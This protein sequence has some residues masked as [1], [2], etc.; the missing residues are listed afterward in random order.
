M[1]AVLNSRVFILAPLGR[2]AAIA[3][4]LLQEA[5]IGSEICADFSAFEGALGDDTC[6]CVVTEEALRSVDLSIVAAHVREQP[7]WSDLPF[8]ILTHRGGEADRNSE[9]L[10]ELLGNVTFLERPFRPTTFV[11]VARTAL[12]GRQRQYEARTRIEQL[13]EGEER[14]RTALLA[15]HLGSWELDVASRTLTASAT[16]KA[17]F[18]R[19]A[20]EPFSYDDLIASIHPDDSERMQEAVRISIDRGID[21]AIEYR[22]VWRDRTVHWAEIRARLV[23]DRTTG[24]SRL[25]GVSADITE[26][27]AAEYGLK[28]LNETL[29]ERVAERTAELNRAHT[30][31]LAQIAQRQHTEELLRQS[32]KMD[33]IGQLT[34]GIAHDFNNLLMAVLGNLTLLRKQPSND[35]RTLRLIEGAL[36]GAERGAALTQRLL[37]FARRQEL[38]LEP[39]SLVDL[40]RGMNDLIERSAGSQVE[41]AFDL[42]ETLP[43]A[44]VDANQFELALLNL[45]VNAR[46]AMP[47]GGLLTIKVDSTQVGA[48]GELST[49][50]YVRLTVSD[51]GQGMDAETLRKATEPFFSTKGVGKGTG[52]G[53]S[54]IQGLA[55]QMN[56]TLRLKS[57]LG[58]GATAE[59][60]IPVTTVHAVKQ[61]TAAPE[62]RE[63]DD[64]KI[65][66][67]VV[68]DDAL[69]AMSTVD[70]LEDLGHEVVSAGSAAHA[71]EILRNGQHVD[72]LITDYS[73]PRMNG[74]ELAKAVSKLRPGTPILLATGYAELPTGSGV[75]LPRIGKPYQQDQLAAEITK[76][77]G[78]EDKRLCDGVRAGGNQAYGV[79]LDRPPVRP[80]LACRDPGP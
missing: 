9:R 76:V 41:L 18:G 61:T 80:A 30:A 66:V 10:S 78:S 63:A 58:Q 16:C 32:Q 6:F 21:C 43:L 14:L 26:R 69:I 37:A 38:N 36:Q 51:N 23:R 53:L 68:D 1:A 75:D 8:I 73:M 44:L 55:S 67:L 65:T 50:A 3:R 11:S 70:M 4:A 42:P 31:V 77:L 2:D 79:G 5:G 34:G 74:V 25:V 45:V 13:H 56:G 29:E 35:A 24:N 62:A 59:L 39:R 57:Q 64:R 46:D 28:R 72:L 54:M 49:G 22:N 33:T 48:G 17:L 40:V 47:N 12:K 52:L 71:L 20:D 7:A 60:W 19:A 27:K 15:G